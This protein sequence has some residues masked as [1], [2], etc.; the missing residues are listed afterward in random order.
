MGVQDGQGP[1]RRR[2]FTVIEL[3]MTVV[4]LG[5]LAAQVWPRFA[6]R[7]AFDTRGFSDQTRAAVQYARKVAMAS[8]RNV[9]VAA[10]GTTLALT[11]ATARGRDA[12]CTVA[13]ANPATGAD[14][15]L[16]A[17]EETGYGGALSLVFHADGTPSAAGALIVQ[18]T[19]DVT[20]RID[21]TTGYVR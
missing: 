10:S 17:P 1:G 20:I 12:A 14:Y 6:D 11:M 3:V 5:V 2:G 4:I 15:V 19:R 13:V 18:G 7:R 8:G 16:T 21:G 9:Q